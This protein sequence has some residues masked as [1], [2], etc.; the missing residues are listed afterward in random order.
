MEKYFIKRALTNI[1]IMF[2][3]LF[4]ISFFIFFATC[5]KKVEQPT[6]DL[7]NKIY[8]MRIYYT[9]DGKFNDIISRF[10][11]HT[12]KLFEKHGFNNVGY[13]TTLKR[14]SVSYADN[15]TFQNQG[16]PAL[17]YIVSFKDME[18]RDEA[19]SNF[20]NDPEWKKVVNESTI[21]GPIVKKIE[22]VFL[23]PTVF[24]NLK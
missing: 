3:K 8:E 12:T 23:N 6:K 21:N 1:R 18:F 14:D 13:W 2:K 9:H 7:S 17:V 20:I 19:W 22:Q 5:T 24:S 15:F 16:K 10:E 4:I 11:N